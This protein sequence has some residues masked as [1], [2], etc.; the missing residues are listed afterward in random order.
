MYRVGYKFNY[1][2]GCYITTTTT[3]T[4]TTTNNNNNNLKWKF[5]SAEPIKNQDE[6]INTHTQHYDTI[7]HNNN[8]KAQYT[9]KFMLHL[10]RHTCVITGRS[11]H[12]M[13]KV[14]HP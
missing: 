13:I 7:T 8:N 3:T 14:Q 6:Y 11:L 1:H 4:T 2:Y 12:V 5:N 10:Q 9:R